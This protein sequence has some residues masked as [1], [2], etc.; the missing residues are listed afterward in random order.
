MKKNNFILIATDNEELTG[1]FAPAF[2]IAEF[3]LG[4]RQWP[5]YEGTRNRRNVGVGDNVLVYCGGSKKLSQCLIGYAKV[6]SIQPFKS[7]SHSDELDKYLTNTPSQVLF[8][9]EP[10][11]FSEPIQFRSILPNLECCPSNLQKWGVILH[12][13]VKKI[14]DNDFSYI[15]GKS[16]L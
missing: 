13:G 11:I 9:N 7:R 2:E 6:A 5:M 8:L 15:L 12:G 14:S 4:L 10:V 3:R 1:R 16:N